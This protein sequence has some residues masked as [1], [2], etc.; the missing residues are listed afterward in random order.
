ML[1]GILGSLTLGTVGGLAINAIQFYA[2]HRAKISIAA[3]AATA[4]RARTKRTDSKGEG[5]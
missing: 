4:I 1:A 3:T 2:A 5:K